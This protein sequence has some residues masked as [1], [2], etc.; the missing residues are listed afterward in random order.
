MRAAVALSLLLIVVPVVHAADI[1]AGK[2][3]VQAVCAACH[4]ANGVSV[5]DTIPNLAGQKATY[6]ETQLK[7]LRE[8]S[9]KNP[10]MNAIAGQLKDDEIV[11][12]AA[13]FSSLQGAASGARSAF[14][15]NVAK[16]GVTFP[17][18]YKSTF[19]KYHTINF[20]ATRQVRY[21][22]ANPAAVQAAREGK[23]LPNGS[24]LFAEVYSAKLDADKKPVMGPDG[25]FVP[26]QLTGY[27]AMERE[28]GWGKE[29]PDM[30][31]NED[32]N[33]AVFTLEKQ[34]R[35]TINQAECLACHK[36]LEKSSFTFTLK[37]LT[38]V[39]KKK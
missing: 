29:I 20:P 19:T 2:A 16:S 4:G 23:D 38:E 36:P 27:T 25:F 1:E 18:N 14:L 30:L 9:R 21:Y 17:A 32:W 24:V 39:A 28:A 5:S 7:A 8:G 37:E 3:K 33:Y 13:F 34:Q 35:P 22:F 31:R 10:I 26:D 6:V 12:V 11:N 15:P